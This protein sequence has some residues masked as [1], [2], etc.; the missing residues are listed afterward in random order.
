[1]LLK[2]I[3]VAL[4]AV[5]AEAHAWCDGV[6]EK[7]HDFA[8]CGDC[9]GSAS[10]DPDINGDGNNLSCKTTFPGTD[11]DDEYIGTC[12]D[13]LPVEE[14]EEE[15][16]DDI[17]DADED[18]CYTREDGICSGCKGAWNTDGRWCPRADGVWENES[19]GESWSEASH[20]LLHPPCSMTCTLD[21]ATKVISAIHDTTSGHD[22]HRCYHDATVSAT[23]CTCSC[24]RP[25]PEDEC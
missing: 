24:L 12:V 4:V 20:P 2:I 9:Q 23:A 16:E 11:G 21:S 22:F 17:E 8:S 19:T 1:M 10:C 3:L 25:C 18:G 13:G 7:S 15:E 14:E 6:V 5:G